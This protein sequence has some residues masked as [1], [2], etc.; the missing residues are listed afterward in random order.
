MIWAAVSGYALV[1]L[2][3]ARLVAGHIAW[4]YNQAEK[5]KSAKRWPHV[6]S[7]LD[8][9]APNIPLWMMGWTMAIPVCLLWPIALPVWAL[10]RRWQI[11]AERESRA[12]TRARAREKRLEKTDR[13]EKELLR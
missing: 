5:A 6:H 3:G 7:D 8:Y 12:Y 1:A 13:L 2:A 11:G 9:V 10:G 4:R